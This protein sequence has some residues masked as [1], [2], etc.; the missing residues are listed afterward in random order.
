MC[1]LNFNH[2]L[3]SFALFMFLNHYPN[4]A[5]H[6]SWNQ[7]VLPPPAPKHPVS[8]GRSLCW[9]P[10]ST[11]FLSTPPPLCLAS[12][13][14][15]A[16]AA[17]ATVHCLRRRRRPMSR[18]PP[19]AAWDGWSLPLALSRMGRREGHPSRQPSPRPPLFVAFRRSSSGIEGRNR[20]LLSRNKT[21]KFIRRK[22]S[23][24]VTVVST[25]AL[26]DWI[27]FSMAFLTA[28]RASTSDCSRFVRSAFLLRHLWKASVHNVWYIPGQRYRRYPIREILSG[29]GK[30]SI[31]RLRD[32]ALQMWRRV[33]ATRTRTFA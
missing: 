18:S 26:S 13:T 5:P 2:V 16:F 19:V 25:C 6:L 27:S 3:M 8:P 28:S 7:L 24:W 29:V 12:V 15:A 23:L 32:P 30:S 31:P 10:R 1:D 33:R 14:V 11:A 20:A 4:P 17:M 21:S 9:A 22:L